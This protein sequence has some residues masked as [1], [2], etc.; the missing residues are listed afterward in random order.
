M[1]WRLKTCWSIL[2]TSRQFSFKLKNLITFLCALHH[3]QRLI[4]SRYTLW[5]SQIC[6]VSALI[7]SLTKSNKGSECCINPSANIRYG[8]S[9]D[10]WKAL[11]K[12]YL[13]GES[14]SAFY[15]RTALYCKENRYSSLSACNRENSH[16]SST[17]SHHQHFHCF[18]CCR[19]SIEQ[20]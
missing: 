12:V 14:V 19:P 7:E 15:S 11:R 1:L 13:R 17:L 5:D 16:L 8:S 18:S 6:F 4:P 2:R 9:I 10:Y 3:R 20:S